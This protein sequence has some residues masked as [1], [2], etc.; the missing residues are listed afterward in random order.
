MTNERYFHIS[1][2]NYRS[3]NLNLNQ[4]EWR[5]GVVITLEKRR[6]NKNFISWTND[7]SQIAFFVKSCIGWVSKLAGCL[8][9]GFLIQERLI[10]SPFVTFSP[11]EKKS[12]WE[13]AVIWPQLTTG[14][15]KIAD[16]DSLYNTYMALHLFLTLTQISRKAFS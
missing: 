16:E 6:S 3:A 15:S 12:L 4:N 8:G 2:I 10:S 14:C 11:S 9:S 7:G 5:S 1:F 13:I